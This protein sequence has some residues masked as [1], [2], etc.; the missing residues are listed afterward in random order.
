MSGNHAWRRTSDA[1]H[2]TAKKAKIIYPPPR[3]V[4][5]IL[6]AWVDLKVR[7]PLRPWTVISSRL[8]GGTQDV[9]PLFSQTYSEVGEERDEFSPLKSN[10][11]PKESMSLFLWFFFC[12]SFL[13]VQLLTYVHVSSKPWATDGSAKQPPRSHVRLLMETPDWKAL[14]AANALT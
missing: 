7:K 13:Y 4:D 12:F 3:G 8:P 14:E 10:K 6:S 5:I 9:A 1:G 2:R 11:P